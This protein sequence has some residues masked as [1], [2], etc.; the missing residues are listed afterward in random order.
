VGAGCELH[1]EAT[2]HEKRRVEM[3]D[4][5]CTIIGYAIGDNIESYAFC[6]N[7]DSLNEYAVEVYEESAEEFAARFGYEPEDFIG[8]WFLEVNGKVYFMLSEGIDQKSVRTLH[9][10]LTEYVQ[11][12]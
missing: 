11:I 2:Q 9:Q 6:P 10:F 8:V 7:E 12:G 3:K 5:N 1:G 4:Y